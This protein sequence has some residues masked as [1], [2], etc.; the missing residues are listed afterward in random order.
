[1]MNKK[2]L[3]LVL[4]VALLFVAAGAVSASTN[5]PETVQIQPD[6]SLDV[7]CDG[8]MVASVENN[9]G[10]SVVHVSCYEVD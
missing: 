9:L 6:T 5:P 3:I 8:F 4:V 2:L 10:Q 7:T 1:M